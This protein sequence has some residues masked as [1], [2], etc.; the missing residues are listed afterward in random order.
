MKIDKAHNGLLFEAFFIMKHAFPYFLK[1]FLLKENSKDK[2]IVVMC[3]LLLQ[4]FTITL[5][6]FDCL[7]SST[8]NSEGFVL[9]T[10]CIYLTYISE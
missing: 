8:I 7:A 9:H 3:G 2:S 4:A 6:I 1:H 10:T 5:T